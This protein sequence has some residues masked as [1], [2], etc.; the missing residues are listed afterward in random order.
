MAYK[1]LILL[2]FCV[3]VGDKHSKRFCR[4]KRIQSLLV[5]ALA[6][7][8]LILFVRTIVTTTQRSRQAGADI[9]LLGVILILRKC[10]PESS[11]VH[12][13]FKVLLSNGLCISVNDLCQSGDGDIMA[14]AD[15][16]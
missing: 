2:V 15:P 13:L 1:T 11:F 3:L 4:G 5:N 8:Y 6:V 16:D 7:Q 10:Q 14:L 9:S 12:Q